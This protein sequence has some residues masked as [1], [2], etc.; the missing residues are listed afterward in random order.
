MPK[1]PTKQGQNG[2]HF[3][4][5]KLIKNT[6]KYTMNVIAVLYTIYCYAGSG[7]CIIDTVLF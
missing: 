7:S 3:V 6:V 4:S 2:M 1:L 5:S